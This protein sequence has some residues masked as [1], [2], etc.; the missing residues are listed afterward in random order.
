M[1]STGVVLA[2]GIARSTRC[3]TRIPA[4]GRTGLR[5]S[6]TVQLQAC[7]RRAGRGIPRRRTNWPGA[8]DE[9]CWARP[10]SRTAG[11][12]RP[13]SWPRMTAS[14][15]ARDHGSGRI[16]PDDSSRSTQV[17]QDRRRRQCRC[18]RSDNGRTCHRP[19]GANNSRDRPGR[20][21]RRRADWARLA[22]CSVP[23]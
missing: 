3:G 22:R 2:S 19:V 15:G 14:N 16:G 10:S 20:S 4:A 9:H 7:L 21:R 6:S 5:L 8:A 17:P 13:V 23:A 18:R 12:R 11:A 1:W